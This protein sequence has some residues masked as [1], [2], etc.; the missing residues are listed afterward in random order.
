M[1]RLVWNGPQRLEWSFQYQPDSRGKVGDYWQRLKRFMVGF[2]ARSVLLCQ[3]WG[4]TVS[5]AEH[6]MFLLVEKVHQESEV[7]YW[8]DFSRHWEAMKFSLF[9]LGYTEILMIN[10]RN[11]QEGTWNVKRSSSR[12]KNVLIEISRYFGYWEDLD[13]SLFFKDFINTIMARTC[14]VCLQIPFENKKKLIIYI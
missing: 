4:C 9:F 10:F 2:L 1:H 5:F 7:S 6:R 11:N 3:Y 12:T 14:T 8:E 13:F